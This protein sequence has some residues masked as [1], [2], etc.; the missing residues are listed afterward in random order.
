MENENHIANSAAGLK[1]VFTID[2][3]KNVQIV[4]VQIVM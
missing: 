2:E 4:L 3:D 1:F